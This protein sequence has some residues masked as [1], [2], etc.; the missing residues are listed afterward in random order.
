VKEFLSRAGHEFT[1]RNVEEDE[2]AFGELMAL[3]FRAIPVT[4]IDGRPIAGYDE[5]KLRDALQREG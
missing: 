2:S 4:V 1:E 3:G 5:A